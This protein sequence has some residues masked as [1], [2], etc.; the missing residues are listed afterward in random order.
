MN[1]LA[2]CYKIFRIT[3]QARFREIKKLY[4]KRALK[5]HPAFPHNRHRK[6]RFVSLFM[7]YKALEFVYTENKRIKVDR[8]KLFKIWDEKHRDR[9]YQECLKVMSLSKEEFEK[10]IFVGFRKLVRT[11][12][13]FFLA[14]LCFALFFPVKLYMNG[15][16]PL[17]ALIFIVMACTFTPVMYLVKIIKRE[18]RIENRIKATKVIPSKFG[19]TFH[20]KVNIKNTT[21]KT[22]PEKTTS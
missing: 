20:K 18:E 21:H 22:F 11:I 2:D 3:S 9:A 4:K 10:S 17:L 13:G 6:G 15:E 8:N 16:L 1:N 7:A 19:F 12:Y 14:V 5:Y